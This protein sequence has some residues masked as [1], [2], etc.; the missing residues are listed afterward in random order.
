MSAP[1]TPWSDPPR[2][3]SNERRRAPVSG[4]AR[5]G[6]G[7]E[8]SGRRGEGTVGNP[9]P[10]PETAVFGPPVPYSPGEEL[11]GKASVETGENFPPEQPQPDPEPQP[12]LQPEPPSR[13]GLLIGI[14][15]LLLIFIGLLPLMLQDNSTSTGSSSSAKAPPVAPTST[16]VAPVAKATKFFRGLAI[17]KVTANDGS[18]LT[19]EGV[20][21]STALVRVDTRTR[22]LMLASPRA[23]DVRIGTMIVVQGDQASDGT[24]QARLILGGA[25]AASFGR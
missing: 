13:T 19:V 10:M 25:L 5:V 24:I 18:T 22:V 20:L 9:G 11:Y 3:W 8:Q 2:I 1:K 14:G 15:V 6:A 7:G 16:K 4:P 12:Q 17:G 23:S 21:G